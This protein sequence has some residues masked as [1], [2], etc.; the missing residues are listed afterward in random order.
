L[1]LASLAMNRFTPIVVLAVGLVL[2]VGHV[3]AADPPRPNPGGSFS[4]GGPT[5]TFRLGSGSNFCNIF[6]NPS[7]T[8]SASNRTLHFGGIIQCTFVDSLVVIAT[9]YRV[10][11]SGSN[12]EYHWE[13]SLSVGNVGSSL[14]TPQSPDLCVSS[15]PTRWQLY[16]RGGANS[17]GEA[18]GWS[19]EVTLPCGEI[20]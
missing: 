3:A 8:Y 5:S 10:T 2:A 11:G 15:A 18:G 14:S 6:T 19:S 4:G 17:L 20:V 1:T 9:L 12:L 7:P 16:V 13:D